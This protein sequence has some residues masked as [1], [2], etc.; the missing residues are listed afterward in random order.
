EGA[1]PFAARDPMRVIPAAMAGSAVA[2]AISLGLGAGSIVPHGGILDLFVPNAIENV[3]G[4]ALAIAAGTFAT[5]SVL[6]VTKRMTAPARTRPE[7]ALA[8]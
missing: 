3:A 1:I 2:G 7:P 4:W 5:T 8:A 6:F